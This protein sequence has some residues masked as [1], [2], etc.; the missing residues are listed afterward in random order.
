[1][2]HQSDTHTKR[3]IVAEQDLATS[4]LIAELLKSAGCMPLCYA[5]WL[6]SV[7]TIVQA[8]AD[9]LILDL[10][11]GASS[12]TLDLIDELRRNKHTHVLPIIV[13]STDERLLAQLAMSLHDLGC[14]T[15][16]KPFELDDF[17]SSIQTCLD[18]GSQT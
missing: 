10:G 2:H 1:M 17:F 7:P 15:L 3:V 9:L 8:Q 12:A 4:E 6:L 14:M 13:N 5:S 16:A 11:R 18:S